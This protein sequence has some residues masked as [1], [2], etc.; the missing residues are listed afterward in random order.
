MTQAENHE[1]EAR[2]DSSLDP[3]D[4]ALVIGHGHG[5]VQLFQ[6][7]LE[8]CG[9]PRRRAA[10]IPRTRRL[11]VHVST[12]LEDVSEKPSLDDLMLAQRL[13]AVRENFESTLLVLLCLQPFAFFLGVFY[14]F[15]FAA[16][17]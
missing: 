8:T 4:H 15:V 11:R 9:V 12:V 6:Y 2:C 14:L 10:C 1:L 13:L 17:D 16:E 3:V 7:F 5:R